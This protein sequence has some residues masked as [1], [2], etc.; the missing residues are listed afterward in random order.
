M[1]KVHQIYTELSLNH[2]MV[3]HKAKASKSVIANVSTVH[4]K[5]NSKCI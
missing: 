2:Q 4:Q 1:S 5:S 3:E